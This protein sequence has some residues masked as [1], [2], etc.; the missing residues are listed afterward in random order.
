[1]GAARL[2]RHWRGEPTR[3]GAGL[4]TPLTRS[5]VHVDR[6]R[7]Q[8][9]PP[10]TCGGGRITR[11]RRPSALQDWRLR[12][13][14]R[15]PSDTKCLPLARGGLVIIPNGTSATI[16]VMLDLRC[17]SSESKLSPLTLTRSTQ[18]FESGGVSSPGCGKTQVPDG[19]HC[20]PNYSSDTRSQHVH[21]QLMIQRCHRAR[22]SLK[23]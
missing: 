7:P 9:G 23:L 1:M 22:P 14:L 21:V 15:R 3:A 2:H 8:W 20:L 17:F 11:G 19:A 16:S 13:F 18:H 12:P 5:P 6:S 10:S 4:R